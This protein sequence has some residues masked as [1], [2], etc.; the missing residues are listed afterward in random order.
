MSKCFQIWM[1]F[2]FIPLLSVFSADT[3]TILALGDSITSRKD[4]YRSVLIPALEDKGIE[5]EF[6]GPNKDTI[7]RHAGYGGKNTKSLLRISKDIYG[8]YPADIVMIH[9]GHNSFSKDKPVQGIIRDTK[10]IIETIRSINP[11]VTILLA[12]VIPA[13]KLPKYS[14]VPELNREL[15]TLSKD[16]MSKESK[17]ILVNQAD[18]FDWKTDT[19]KD[20]VHPSASGAKKMADK[21]MDALLPLLD[22]KNANKALKATR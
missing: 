6:I 4:S 3:T 7:S 22:R 2:Q 15:E 8:K 10:A 12:Q 21:W 14:Y 11:K 13:G 5:H 19:I 9:S 18:G 17:V 20:K 1:I 16:L